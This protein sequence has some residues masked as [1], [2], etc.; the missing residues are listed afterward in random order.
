MSRRFLFLAT[1]VLLPITT[2][3][4][5]RAIGR[6]LPVVGEETFA[7]EALQR[8][9]D[10]VLKPEEIGAYRARIRCRCGVLRCHAVTSL[11]VV[12]TAIVPAATGSG[13][14]PRGAP[15]GQMPPG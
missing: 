13:A 12:V 3:A 8:L 6:T 4:A 10:A 11:N 5:Q 2:V 15:S 1:L 9:D 14:D 7:V